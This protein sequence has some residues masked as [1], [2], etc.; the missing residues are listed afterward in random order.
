MRDVQ[1]S[2]DLTDARQADRPR[3][4]AA[5]SCRAQTAAATTILIV[6]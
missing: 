4:A 1:P 2:N 3:V 5:A 6:A